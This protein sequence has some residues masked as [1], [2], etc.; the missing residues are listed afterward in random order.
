MMGKRMPTI[1]EKIHHWWINKPDEPNYDLAWKLD[2]EIWVA[3]VK[4]ITNSNEEKQLR[5]GLGQLLRYC[6]LLKT[7]GKVRGI[8]AIER[9]ASDAMWIELC[10]THNILL[11]WL[12]VFSEKILEDR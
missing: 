1:K 3:E 2:D 12:D 5:P 6:Q 7:K 9:A 10:K 11:V 8:L 4:S